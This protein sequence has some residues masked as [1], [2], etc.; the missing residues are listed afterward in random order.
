MSLPVILVATGFLGVLGHDGPDW[1]H[2]AVIAMVGMVCLL[3]GIGALACIA[4]AMAGKKLTGM[5]VVAM[6]G[7]AL[8]VAFVVLIYGVDL[9]QLLVE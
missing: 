9:W 8:A 2:W 5:D 7:G 3:S 4:Y 6:L 1:I